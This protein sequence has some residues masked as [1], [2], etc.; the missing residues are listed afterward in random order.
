MMLR[1]VRC[2]LE[3]GEGNGTGMVRNMMLDV[4]APV[5]MVGSPVK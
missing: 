4:L 1:K 5:V 2:W 3:N